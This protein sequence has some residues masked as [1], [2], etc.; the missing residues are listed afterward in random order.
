ML[1]REL[2]IIEMKQEVNERCHRLGEVGR[3]PLEFEQDGKEGLT[4][5]DRGINHE[6]L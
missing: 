5:R 4:R 6:F 1:R 2:G 3:Y